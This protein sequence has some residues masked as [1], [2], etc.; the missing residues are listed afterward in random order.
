MIL[1][2]FKQ[3]HNLINNLYL[4]K[5]FNIPIN[6]FSNS[7]ILQ[8]SKVPNVFIL[9]FQELQFVKQSEFGMCNFKNSFKQIHQKSQFSNCNRFP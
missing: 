6:D 5:T 8:S 9:K 4:I 2:S 7:N 1:I 3:I